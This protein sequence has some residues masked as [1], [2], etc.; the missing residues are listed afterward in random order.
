MYRVDINSL[1]L[2]ESLLCV[3]PEKRISA[4]AALCHGFFAGIAAKNPLWSSDLPK[5]ECHEY[6]SAVE[7]YNHKIKSLSTKTADTNSRS[8]ANIVASEG[9]AH[10]NKITNGKRK[11][12][13][14]GDD[15]P[16]ISCFAPIKKRLDF[17]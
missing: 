15:D 11:S 7:A 8:S 5:K 14:D 4:S 10:Q 13:I 6:L 16:E 1:E 3:D 2:L 9:L 17:S 12:I